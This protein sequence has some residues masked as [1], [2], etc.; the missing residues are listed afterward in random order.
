MPHPRTR[1][2]ALVVAATAF[3]ITLTAAPAAHAAPT[4]GE[5]T[6]Q[7]DKA[8]NQLEVVVESYNAMNISLKKTHDEQ[9]KLAAS[10]APA[11]AALTAASA[12]VDTIA[13]TSYMQ[14]RVGPMSAMIG[15]DQSDLMDRMSYLDQITRANQRDIDTFTETTQTYAERQTA[16]KVTQDKQAAQV[17]ELA[18]RKKK[19]E[20]DIKK[21]KGL[22]TAAYG[23]ASEPGKAYTGSVPSVSGSAGVA[24]RFAFNAIGSSYVFG[25]DGPNSYD[26]SGLVM[27]AWGAAGES[28][29]HNARSQWGQV[30]HISRSALQ[31]GDLVF[32]NSLAHVGIYVGDNMIIDAP[33]Q[34]EPVDKRSINRG[35]PIYGYGRVT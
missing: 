7:I 4:T 12:Q 28:L 5:L 23:R 33:R 22:R 19:I 25:A 17:K 13:T 1:L 9:K 27:R 3:A 8:S 24:V 32:Y 35:M 26:C 31:P 10:L 2:R 34:G 14:G 15:G 20:T 29:P 30:A 21:L 16:L 18:A 6:K 11:K